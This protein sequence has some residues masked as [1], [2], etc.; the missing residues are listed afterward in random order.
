MALAYIGLSNN[1]GNGIKIFARTQHALKKIPHARLQTISPLYQTAPVGCPGKQRF[2]YNAVAQITT[3]RA[4][5][6]IHQQLQKIERK[7]QKKTRR[8]NAPR[9]LDLDYLFHGNATVKHRQLQIPHPRLH[10][11]AFVLKPLL[12][13][14]SYNDTKHGSYKKL[15]AAYKKCANQQITCL[16]PR[17]TFFYDHTTRH[18]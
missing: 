2:Y 16:S 15:T 7:I 9:Y 10:G 13:I 8:R 5:R 4:P 6:Q 11:R 1:R 3:H 12:D 17:H 18:R 14:L